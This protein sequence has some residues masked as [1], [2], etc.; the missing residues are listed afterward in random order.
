MLYLLFQVDGLRLDARACTPLMWACARGHAK[1]AEVLVHV[2]PD[3]LRVANS[4]GLLPIQVG[5]FPAAASACANLQK[6]GEMKA[7]FQLNAEI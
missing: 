1:T 7:M 3:A 6:K 5:L 4:A 2:S